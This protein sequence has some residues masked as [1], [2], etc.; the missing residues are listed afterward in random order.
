MVEG[1]PIWDNTGTE[2]GW[3]S[4]VHEPFIIIRDY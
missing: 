2:D 4:N 3:K 1:D